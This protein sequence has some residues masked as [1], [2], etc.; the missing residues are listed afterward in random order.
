VGFRLQAGQELGD[1][2][3]PDA[4][5]RDNFTRTTREYRNDPDDNGVPSPVHVQTF[6]ETSTRTHSTSY[7]DVAAPFLLDA[8]R[9]SRIEPRVGYRRLERS[10]SFEQ[11]ARFED[12]L[13]EPRTPA[14]LLDARRDLVHRWNAGGAYE[15]RFPA[16]WR[17]TADLE[18]YGWITPDV[19]A[20]DIAQQLIYDPNSGGGT[21]EAESFGPRDETNVVEERRGRI[22]FVGDAGLGYRIGFSV[23]GRRFRVDSEPT[24]SLY[25]RREPTVRYDLVE[26]RTRRLKGTPEADGDFPEEQWDTATETTESFTPVGPAENVSG[27]RLTSGA[28]LALP[29]AMEAQLFGGGF[30]LTL[31]GRVAGNVT[32]VSEYGRTYQVTE[33]TTNLL[34]NQTGEETERRADIPSY[35]RSTAFDLEVNVRAGFRTILAGGELSFLLESAGPISSLDELTGQVIFALPAGR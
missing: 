34:T 27:V 35:S 23:P 22:G 19:R 15:L 6:V 12:D 7:V 18:A 16:G 1:P 13:N 11:Q 14:N 10:R 4:W 26:R 33:T 25:H 17:L 2:D 5:I 29:V 31:G 3:N 21:G 30:I 20:Q 24:L 28:R 32:G 9:V 8:G